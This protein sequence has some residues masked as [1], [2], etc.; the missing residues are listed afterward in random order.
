V[1]KVSLEL[2]LRRVFGKWKCPNV[3]LSLHAQMELIH[4]PNLRNSILLAILRNYSCMLRSCNWGIEA[5]VIWRVNLVRRWGLGG[6]KREFLRRRLWSGYS[7][8]VWRKSLALKLCK[9]K[10][11]KGIHISLCSM[12]LLTL[13]R[14]G[15][16]FSEFFLSI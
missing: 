12:I 9:L 15:L 1:F 16:S 5:L 14:A 8:L 7:D 2:L 4:T 10:I 3:S 13:K 6:G 11:C